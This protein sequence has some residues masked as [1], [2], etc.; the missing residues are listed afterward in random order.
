[1]LGAGVD[2]T[3][4]VWALEKDSSKLIVSA[5]AHTS[6]VTKAVWTSDGTKIVS[7]GE[8]KIWKMWNADKLS[9]IKA[10]KPLSDTP[11]ALSLSPDGLRAAIAR[12]DGKLD[13][14]I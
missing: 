8:D 10:F 7:I 12:V 9:E 4:R 13:L 2:Q 3:L 5:Y 6:G 14:L 1:M 11:L